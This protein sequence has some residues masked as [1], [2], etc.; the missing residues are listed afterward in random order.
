M[1][2]F[3]AIL[4]DEWGNM[5]LDDSMTKK[6]EALVLLTHRPPEEVLNAALDSY[7]E[8]QQKKLVEDELERERKETTFT[9]DEFWDGVDI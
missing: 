9:S 6:L 8:M 4:R 3:L 7:L 2:R 5:Q 1:K